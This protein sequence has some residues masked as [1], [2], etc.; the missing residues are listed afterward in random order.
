MKSLKKY[1]NSEILKEEFERNLGLRPVY[2]PFW[3]NLP[4]CDIFTFLE[5]VCWGVAAVD[6]KDRSC[7][8][9]LVTL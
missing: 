9:K 1:E 8:R 7:G 3:A 2:E 4:H 5:K 6:L